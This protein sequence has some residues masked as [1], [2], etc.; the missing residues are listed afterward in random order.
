M[1]IRCGNFKRE[2]RKNCT[3]YGW[4]GIHHVCDDY[5]TIDSKKNQQQF[6]LGVVVVV[7]ESEDV[8]LD[9]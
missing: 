8:M 2:K 1:M 5:A 3:V 4:R 6:F 9:R 7:S